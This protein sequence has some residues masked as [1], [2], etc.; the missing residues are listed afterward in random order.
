MPIPASSKQ[1]TVPFWERMRP[2]LAYP[3]HSE[4]LLTI[5][6]LAALRLLGYVPGV[7]WLLNIII[8][9]ATFKYAAEVLSAT[10][11]G[12]LE[13]PTGYSTPDSVGWVVLK[14]VVL[15]W[16]MA[17]VA[18]IALGYVG[19]G[20]LAWIA[21]LAIALGAPAALMSAAIDQDTF[22]ALNPA[23]WWATISR[24]G[25]PY[26]G[27]SLLCLIITYSEANAKSMLL[28][29]LPGPV[30]I[31]GHHFIAN[32][33]TVVTFHLLGYLVYQYRDELGYEIKATAPTALPRPLDR[34]QAIID[35]SERL[36][37]NGETHEAARVL[38]SH[39]NERG[40]TDAAH[41]RYRKLL[42]LH[43]DQPGL[44]KHA[45]QYL[46]VLIAHDKWRAALDFWAEC[47]AANA[48][49]WPSDPEQVRE[50]V[51]KAHELG[52]PALA[53]KFANG[54]SRANPKHTSVP[55][56]HLR[57][58]QALAEAL[59]Q[60][61]QARGLLDAT[62]AAYPRSKFLPEIEAYRARL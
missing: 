62:A 24:I 18:V 13:A 16:I 25:W 55:W 57:V 21:A 12:S 37:A 23:L 42:T 10:A 26:V 28:P 15:L 44:D 8:I 31:V 27:A 1:Q 61:D 7:G 46:N 19:A 56:V 36:A 32:Y 43:G 9:A 17:I 34:D 58:A 20:N 11:N 39:I 51:D 6:L 45:Q 47:R 50:L 30:A 29:F 4:A 49:L 33:A 5:S 60:P 54:F 3:L 40:G 52:K 2:M 59:G 14:V 38:G 22:G 48:E 53:L 35:E 41:L